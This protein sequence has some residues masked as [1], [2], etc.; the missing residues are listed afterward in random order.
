MK[1]WRDRDFFRPGRM[2]GVDFRVGGGERGSRCVSPVN[3][4]LCSPFV[5]ARAI[6]TFGPMRVTREFARGREM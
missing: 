5:A 3:T 1:T 6:G 4:G 2:H